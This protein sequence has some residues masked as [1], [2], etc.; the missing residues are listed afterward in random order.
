MPLYCIPVADPSNPSHLAHTHH[1][2]QTW[3]TTLGKHAFMSKQESILYCRDLQL[4]RCIP[5]ARRLL[6]FQHLL[7]TAMFLISSAT[8]RTTAVRFLQLR[9]TFRCLF[10]AV[11]AGLRLDKKCWQVSSEGRCC[12]TRGNISYGTLRGNGYRSVN[13]SG[14]SFLVHRLVAF[15]FRGPP[16]N[17]RAWQ[18]HRLDGNPSNN[19]LENLEYVT[20][21]QNMRHS[22]ENPSRGCAGAKLS[23]PAMW[24]TRGSQSWT[25]CESGGRQRSSL[26]SLR[27]VLASVVVE[28]SP[29]DSLRSN[30]PKW[31]TGSREKSGD[32][33][34]ILGLGRN[35]QGGW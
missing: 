8:S 11:S 24:R 1:V 4:C 28:F 29:A 31:K 23:R 19:R 35:C 2:A 34:K 27:V 25:M 20:H 3:L 30:L 32:R 21:Q 16:P 10:G 14:Q 26:G 18:V 17:K 13:I 12:D 9:Y 7:N 22:F 15:A 6:K 5:A 33:C